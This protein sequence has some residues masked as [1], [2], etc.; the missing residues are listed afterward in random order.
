M[1]SRSAAGSW[2]SACGTSGLAWRRL[3]M[4]PGDRVAILS[5]S[6]PEWL[7]ADFAIL[8]SGAVTV[9]IYPTL[10]AEQVAFILR[11]SEASAC[12]RVDADCS[13]RRS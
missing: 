3:G 2:S 1:S 5:E 7:L 9:P 6:R 10:S 8:A 4:A 12:R 13:S 11:D